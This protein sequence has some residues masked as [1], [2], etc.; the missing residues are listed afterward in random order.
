MVAEGQEQPRVHGS[1]QA[2]RDALVLLCPQPTVVCG[3]GGL[4]SPGPASPLTSS[5]RGPTATVTAGTPPQA[6]CPSP[7]LPGPPART[8]P[9]RPAPPG[10][11]ARSQP[12][13]PGPAGSRDKGLSARNRESPQPQRRAS[14]RAGGQPP[15]HTRGK[16]PLPKAAGAPAAVPRA[17]PALGSVSGL[18]IFSPDL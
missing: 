16:W 9:G 8:H 2:P 4:P 17:E 12:G 7:G 3:S 11:G 14:P 10:A 13:V 6:P 15:G 5:A 18:G 1:S